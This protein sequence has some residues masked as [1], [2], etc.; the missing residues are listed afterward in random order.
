MTYQFNPNAVRR[1]LQ[2]ADI[3]Y[4][5]V[6]AKPVL[7]IPLGPGWSG[8]TPWTRAWADPR[9][10]RGSI[11]FALPP[12]DAIDAPALT[13]IHFDRTAWQDVEPM[14]SR[15]RASEAYLALVI[16][17]RTQMMVKVRRLG[18]G[19]SPSIPDV[20]VPVAPGT[21]PAISFAK[22][23][24]ATANTIEE[25]WK[26]RSAVDFGKH[27]SVIAA[28]RVDSLTEW[29]DLLQKLGSVPTITDVNIL[30]MD[31]GQAKVEIAYAGSADQLN[32]Q[33]SRQGLTL[34]SEG[35]QWWLERAGTEAG[36]R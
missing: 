3:A 24:D 26:S 5:D 15:I 28:L 18:P 32:Q 7:I 6:T 2:Q 21:S 9:F 30:A 22:V 36:N 17:Q 31:I 23:A 13:Q 16:P 34:A 12:N 10:A 25:F 19:S 27:A 29:G 35:G 8:Q 1:L 11:P 14:A 33:L 4:S 20:V